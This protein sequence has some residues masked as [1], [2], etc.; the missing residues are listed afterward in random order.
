MVP[1]Q[2]KEPATLTPVVVRTSE[3]AD[4]TLA[5]SIGLLNVAVTAVVRGTDTAP[6]A[7]LTVVA[8]GAVGAVVVVALPLQGRE[9]K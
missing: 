7:G 8:V 6:A 4:C 5:W 9:P 1:L 2:D 3:K